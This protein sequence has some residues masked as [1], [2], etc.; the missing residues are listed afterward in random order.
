M[1]MYKEAIVSTAGRPGYPK[2]K[3]T[4]LTGNDV[5]TVL[6]TGYGKHLCYAC[7]PCLSGI[8]TIKENCQ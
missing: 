2:L 8:A 6:S 7:L 1:D 3:K 5:F 4:L